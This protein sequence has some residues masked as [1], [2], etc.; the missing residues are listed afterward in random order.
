MLSPA[1]ALAA[2]SASLLPARP[3]PARLSRAQLPFTVTVALLAAAS[4]ACSPAQDPPGR[5]TDDRRPT[6]APLLVPPVAPAA[7][8][9]L[10][11]ASPDLLAAPA[12]LSAS[13]S[14]APLAPAAALAAL[15]PG[16]TSAVSREATLP[17]QG[18][19]IAS[20]AMR[21]WIYVAPDDRSTKLGYLRAGAVVDRAEVSAGTQGCA[22]GWY[23]IAP[24][25]YVCVGKGASLELDHPVVAA[26]VRGPRRGAPV[27]YHYVMSRTPPPHLYFRLPTAEDQR[28]VEGPKLAVHLARAAASPSS[29]PLDP[30]PD[31]LL[32]G[33]DLPKPYGA[34]KKLHYSVH[35][36]R[37]KEKSAFGLI[38]TFSWTNRRFGLTTE[39]DLIPLDRTRPARISALRGVVI[40]DLDTEIPESPSDAAPGTDT[41]S[42]ADAASPPG[43]A[44]PAS[45]PTSQAAAAID[46]GGFSIA[47]LP[48]DELPPPPPG[49]DARIDPALRGA[50]AFVR[51]HGTT[52]H[53]PSASTRALVRAGLAPFRSGWVLT[54]RTR[55]GVKGM[56]ETTDGAWLAGA[57]L[58]IAELR[59]DPQG[60]ARAGKK[61][62]DVS[63][64]RQMLVAYEGTR[65]VFAALIS[66]GRSGM[67]DPAETDATI[68]GSFYIHAKHVS[69]TMDGDDEASEAFDLRDV[70]YTQYFR[71]GYALHGAYWHDEFGKARSHGCINLAPA[72]A[73]WL[74]EWTEP[75]VPPEWHGAVNIEGGGTLVY[76]HG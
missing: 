2:S 25:G 38:T 43:S 73:A 21:T 6:P 72:D 10:A 34:E 50:P 22:G 5:A 58:V 52:L 26:A 42:P 45:S 70:P 24:R 40:K 17:G 39:L 12:P 49:T 35:T 19:K 65:P 33:R 37:A 46:A 29:L 64:E 15:A 48:D 63:I 71:G 44:P 16:A 14:A 41:A 32:G 56:V 8:A 47:D 68:R 67:A 20:I 62:I 27:P 30:V 76:V 36:G 31:F 18:A 57:H 11:A 66:S 23:R 74:F 60:F 69:T 1:R 9:A 53:R 4:A 3:L 54:G 59:K 55:G 28:R 75:A 13:P 51:V 61:W 7:P